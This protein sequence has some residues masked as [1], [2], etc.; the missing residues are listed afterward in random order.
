MTPPRLP[1]LW[2]PDRKAPAPAPLCP[3][4]RGIDRGYYARNARR[5]GFMYHRAC[6]CEVEV[7]EVNPCS[8]LIFNV[9]V[10]VTGVTFCTNC[11]VQRRKILSLTPAI[12]GVY[13]GYTNPTGGSGFGWARSFP[14]GLTY[15][16]YAVNG[17]TGSFFDVSPTLELVLGGLC[18]G[19]PAQPKLSAAII[20]A[21]FGAFPGRLFS[22]GV[23]F[24]STAY[25]DFGDTLPNQNTVCGGSISSSDVAVGIT[26]T[27]KAE[28]V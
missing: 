20:R 1:A 16:T 3:E 25:A 22:W 18:T 11:L 6:C 19:S 9:R 28:I 17:C 4:C 7:P 12:N 2:T 24:G 27:I 14:S 26:G 23:P 21:P 5:M 8:T 10:T 15:R 13:T